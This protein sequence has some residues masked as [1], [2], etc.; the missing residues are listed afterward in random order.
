MP[1][2]L[3]IDLDPGIGDALAVIAALC[4]PELDVVALTATAGCVPAHI[5]TRNLQTI[6]EQIDP[7]KRP[8]LG[9]AAENGIEATGDKAEA[10][11][12]IA[13]MHGQSGLGDRDVN[14]ADLHHRH[15]SAKMMTDLVRANPNEYTLLTLGP[16][17]NVEV[18]CERCPDFLSLLGSLVCLGGSVAVGGD[19]NA[20]AEFNM[21]YDPTAARNVLTSPATKTIVPLD[22]SNQVV[23]TFEEFNRL[24]LEPES[25][26]HVFLHDVLSYYLRAHHEHLG[27]EGIQLRELAALAYITHPRYF[28]TQ[29]MVV[30]VETRGELTRGMTVFDRRTTGQWQTNIDVVVDVDTRGVLDYLTDVLKRV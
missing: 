14:V 15:D 12:Q 2:K 1:R 19:A 29:R 18:A 25:A 30:D 6:V 28:E 7:A 26:Q 24:N 21:F 8:R 17:T 3:I 11:R 4:D 27:L 10:I 13:I 20:A 9:A 5:A 16:L 23:M 22:V